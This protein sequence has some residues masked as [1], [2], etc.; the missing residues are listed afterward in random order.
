MDQLWA[1]WRLQYVAKEPKEKSSG[2]V[3]CEKL[4]ETNDNDNF[5]LERAKHNFVILNVYPYNNGHLMI[6]PNRH[7]ADVSDLSAAERIEFFDLMLKYKTII[8]DKMKPH[9]FNI[10][11][12][13][14]SAAGAGIAEHLHLHI[15]P[16]WTG[17]TNFMPVLSDTRVM[18]QSLKACYQLLN[19]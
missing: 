13:C 19:G 1:P 14:G 5:I 10:G 18:P 12:N 8:S 9:G 4:S 6:L 2:C 15:V 11:I 16:R 17:D 3:F 7:I